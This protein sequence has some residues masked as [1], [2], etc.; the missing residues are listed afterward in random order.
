M[1]ADSR[2]VFPPRP[3]TLSRIQVYRRIERVGAHRVCERDMKCAAGK[4]LKEV[5]EGD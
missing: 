5:R 2:E 3:R 1:A 4:A